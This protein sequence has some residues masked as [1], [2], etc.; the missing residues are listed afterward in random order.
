VYAFARADIRARFVNPTKKG[1]V[2]LQSVIE[3]IIN[4]STLAKLPG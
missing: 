4:D 3:P 1:L 2:M